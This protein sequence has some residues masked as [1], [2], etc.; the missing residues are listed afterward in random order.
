MSAAPA[1]QHGGPRGARNQSTVATMLPSKGRV[2]V[3][4]GACV[5][6]NSGVSFLAVFAVPVARC[7]LIPVNVALDIPCYPKRLCASEVAMPVR[8][9]CQLAIV[10]N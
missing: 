1:A 10:V 2:E 7:V 3:A 8:A 5:D 6:L 9:G 4:V